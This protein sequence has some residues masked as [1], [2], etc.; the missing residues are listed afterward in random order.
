[1]LKYSKNDLINLPKKHPFLIG[2]DSDGCVF[3]TMVTKQ[4][5]HFHPLIISLWELEAIEP[6]LRQAAEF[7][8]LYSHW[9]GS[10]RFIA[11]LKMFD[12]LAEWPDVAAKGATLPDTAP[13][14]AYCES[15]LPLGNPSL[16]AEVERTGSAE[17][18][19]VL[20]WSLA[21][22]QDISENMSPCPPF[23]GVR[24]C[25]EKM[26]AVGDLLVVSQTPE[27]ALV[28]EWD[29]HGIRS[30]V[31]VIAGQ[32]LGTKAEHLNMARADRYP[33]DHVLL[34]GDAPGDQKAAQTAGAYFFP[35]MPGN[36]ENSWKKLHDEGLEK[37]LDGSY[38]GAY[39]ENLIQ[40]FHAL[41]PDSPP[42]S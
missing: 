34:I 32:E 29:L 14:R 9:R 7:A 15:G 11:L 3:D 36:E 16:E 31:N 33:K 2:I 26:H 21:V 38:G 37:L 22:N 1:M 13:L 23:T 40:E 25:L 10:N 18:Q 12:L 20:N 5:D 42:W 28:H 8:N 27:V 39:Q 4:C 17:L 41:L 24:E 35:I 19:K 30:F 6:Q